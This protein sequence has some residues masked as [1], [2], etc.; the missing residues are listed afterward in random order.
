MLH[1]GEHFT[2][3]PKSSILVSSDHKTFWHMTSKS[4][5]WFVAY[6]K[7]DSRCAFLSNGFLRIGQTSGVLGILLSHAHS[8]QSLSW[9]HV[10]SSKLPLASWWPLW[11]PPCSVIQF[12]GRP[13]LGS[14]GDTIHL[15]LL[16]DCL[17]CAPRDIQGPWNI[18]IPIP[19]S[20]PFHNY[21][22]EVFWKLLG[23]HG[24]VFVEQRK[25]TGTA[26]FI[27]KLEGHSGEH[28]PSPHNAWSMITNGAQYICEIS[29]YTGLYR[30][31]P[32]LSMVKNHFRN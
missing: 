20:V 15:P 19:W 18:V 32:Y 30:Y 28:I 7:R 1:S 3:K 13:D 29:C 12:K 23:A 24:W 21:I 27:L 16:N 17:V 8:D 5:E 31:W 6:L 9:R 25:P 14:R 26:D 10:A 22:P 2:F 11:T 4:P